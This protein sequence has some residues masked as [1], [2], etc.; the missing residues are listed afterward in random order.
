MWK[1]L[2]TGQIQLKI[3]RRQAEEIYYSVLVTPFW[4]KVRAFSLRP[5]IKKQLDGIDYKVL[6]R[7]LSL[8][9]SWTT[10]ELE[11]H[12]ENLQRILRIA[13]VDIA[14]NQKRV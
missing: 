1:S 5:A 10:E 13:C 14:E 6:A 4:D 2:N 3:S 8:F 9:D 12:D 7:E 11:N